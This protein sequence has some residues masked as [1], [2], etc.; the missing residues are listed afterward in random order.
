MI[1]FEYSIKACM[2]SRYIEFYWG[3]KGDLGNKAGKRI[4]RK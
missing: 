4:Y 1:T 3:I 2:L